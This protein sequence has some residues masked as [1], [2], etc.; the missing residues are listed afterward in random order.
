VQIPTASP[1]VAAI[2]TPVTSTTPAF[3]P[4]AAPEAVAPPRYTKLFRAQR[5]A[6][7]TASSKPA[8]IEA[9][10][11]VTGFEL[12][13]LSPQ[14]RPVHRR[15]SKGE[16]KPRKMAAPAV[17]EVAPQQIEIKGNADSCFAVQLPGRETLTLTSLVLS[18]EGVV[19]L[20]QEVLRRVGQAAFLDQLDA[21]VDTKNLGVLS[22]GSRRIPLVT[23]ARGPYGAEAFAYIEQTSEGEAVRVLMTT[24]QSANVE[25]GSPTEHQSNCQL[26]STYL[27]RERGGSTVLGTLQRAVL[28]REAGNPEPTAINYRVG[29][30]LSLSQASA[31]PEPLL[32]ITLRALDEAPPGIPVGRPA[33]P[34][35]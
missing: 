16:R 1:A 23:V 33:P 4:F 18:E 21:W 25:E 8:E 7:F 2:A 19:P 17:I 34:P 29:F 9:G 15:W 31:D 35:G 6:D 22:A 24:E 3:V 14:P 11:Q 13:S 12:V 30:S 32:S 10:A 28:L 5:P 27:R 26:A 20:R